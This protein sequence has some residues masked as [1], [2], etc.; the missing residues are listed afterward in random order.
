[1]LNSTPATTEAA[2]SPG[3]VRM[4]FQLIVFGV[5]RTIIN[6]AFRLVY[7]FMPFIAAGLSVE[8]NAI[9]QIIVFRSLLGIAAPL[10]GAW[11][12]KLGRKTAMLLGMGIFVCGLALIAI[13]PTYPALAAMIMLVAAAK[14]LFEPAMYAYIGDN[15]DYQQR[16]MAIAVTELGWSGAF[17]LGMPLA[18]RLIELDGWTAPFAWIALTA[19]IVGVLLWRI[20]P[21][22]QGSASNGISLMGNLKSVVTHPTALAGLAVCLVISAANELI[23]ITFGEWLRDDFVL[24]A[25]ALGLAT[26]VIGVAEL[27]GE[28]MVA[29][30][31]D[32]IGKRRAVLLGLALNAAANFA[33]PLLGKT[34]PGAL[35]GLF[36]LFITFE[37]ALVSMIPLMTELLPGARA[38][39]MAANVS[40]FAMGRAL[41]AAIGLFGLT[42]TASTFAAVGL[43]MAAIALLI[44]VVRQE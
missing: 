18:G 28:G 27:G 1:M 24:T 7:P 20:L 3:G 31:V 17:V 44:L 33:L 11:A 12:D 10:M 32:R 19:V 26:V 23:S 4:R 43:D 13:W 8:E 41:G 15:V 40:A 5:T 9:R 25:T 39:L 16:G 42:L 37:F 38:T 29:G 14:I 35:F 22:G 2:P 36:L 6:T 34:L 30:L 21:S